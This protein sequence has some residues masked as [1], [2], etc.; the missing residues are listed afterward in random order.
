MISTSFIAEIEEAKNHYDVRSIYSKEQGNALAKKY[1][2]NVL[3]VGV[4]ASRATPLFDAG[5]V[6]AAGGSVTDA[7]MATDADVLAAAIMTAA[8]KLDEGDVPEYDRYCI[9]RP[10]QYW[11]LLN[12]DLAVNRD[13]TDGGSVRKGKVWEIGGVEIIKSNNLPSTNIATGPAAYR[14]NFSKTYGLV[15]QKGAMG[16]VKLMDLSIESEYLI[17][18]QGTLIVAK[19]AVGHGVLRPECA[20]ELVTP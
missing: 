6:P 7:L 9:L 14:G 11:L 17:T 19:Y 20:V 15:Y 3:Q 4:L 5:T 8:Q 16:T 13:Y 1:D 18:N 10:A 12:S 2:Q